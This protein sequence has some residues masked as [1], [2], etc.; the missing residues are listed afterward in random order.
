MTSTDIREHN[1]NLDTVEAILDKCTLAD[2]LNLI[3]EIA[4]AKADHIR[5]NW[6]D[7]ATAEMW[8]RNAA[9]IMAASDKVARFAGSYPRGGKR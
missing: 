9:I 1:K 8:D 7:G 4:S 2:V 6:Q 5:E 3:A